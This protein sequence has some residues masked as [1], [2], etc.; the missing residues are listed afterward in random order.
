M[1]AETQAKREPK[2]DRARKTREAILDAAERLF[3]DRGLH[4]VT[5]KEIAAEA[6]V[7][8]GTFYTYF[9]DKRALF[10]EL[11]ERHSRAVHQ[12]IRDR[13]GRA[14]SRTN[15]PE[16]VYDLVK[17][18]YEAHNLSPDFHRH[19]EALRYSD[20]E[21]AGMRRGERKGVHDRS[22]Q[23][24]AGFGDR[25]RI[26]DYEAAAE[27]VSLAVEA[28]VHELKMFGSEVSEFRMLRELADMIARYLYR[29]EEP[30]AG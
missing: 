13:V 30:G 23:L 1:V 11:L 28:V 14:A 9:P 20:P 10:L 6:G 3:G 26:S 4:E 25:L 24:L 8:V 2:Q 21:L 7:A 22:A 18:V 19:A 17:A 12:V 27:V 15:G 16:F 5:S 29:D